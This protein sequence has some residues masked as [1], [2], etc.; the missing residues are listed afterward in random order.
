MTVTRKVD[1]RD[2][3]REQTEDAEDD[4][5]LVDERPAR[6]RL[7]SRRSQRTFELVLAH[8]AILSRAALTCSGSTRRAR[9]SGG[10]W[11]RR[12]SIRPRMISGLHSSRDSTGRCTWADHPCK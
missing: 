10:R 3:H 7:D 4:G 9:P 1:A 11:M 12:S 6:L 2:R 8:A 5:E